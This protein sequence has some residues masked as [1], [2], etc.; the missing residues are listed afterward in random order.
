M[1]TDQEK[2]IALLRDLGLNQLEAE[3]Y[4]FLL[5]NEPMTAYR[6]G[7]AIGRPTAN[8]YKSIENLARFG[9]VLV[10]EGTNRVCRA[11]PVEEFIRQ[12]G[13]AHV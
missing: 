3:I 4:T 2:C 12:I 11:V 8:V 7:K 1:E 5:P 13:R 9:A 6:V 10:E